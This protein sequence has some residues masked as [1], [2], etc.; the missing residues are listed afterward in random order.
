MTDNKLTS[1]PP[2]RQSTG[3]VQRRFPGGSHFPCVD[4]TLSRDR[5][6]R[7]V[8]DYSDN[9]RAAKYV[10]RNRARTAAFSCCY[11]IGSEG[12][13]QAKI[14]RSCNPYSRIKGLATAFPQKPK[15]YGLFWSLGHS[16]AQI[17]LMALRAA[18]QIGIR[19]NGEWVSLPGPEAVAF[20]LEVSWGKSVFVDSREFWEQWVVHGAGSQRLSYWTDDRIAE[21]EMV[22][23]LGAR[24]Y[25]EA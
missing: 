23:R 24:R 25:R 4:F 7:R 11:V 3:Y 16:A 15:I 13:A 21:A 20:V 19:A 1:N 2:L 17:E 6:L 8:S 18:T 14:G 10:N 12:S 22:S 9:E 5:V